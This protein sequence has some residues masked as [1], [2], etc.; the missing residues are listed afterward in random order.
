M[1]LFL[2]LQ[3]LVLV[4]VVSV[5]LVVLVVIVLLTK[6]PTNIAARPIISNAPRSMDVRQQHLGGI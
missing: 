3:L 6:I 4:L 1:F 2:F 5:V